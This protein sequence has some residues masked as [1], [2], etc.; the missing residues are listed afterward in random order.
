MARMYSPGYTY[1][2]NRRQRESRTR[3]GQGLVVQSD[4]WKR[5][6]KNKK[7]A[8]QNLA[9]EVAVRSNYYGFTPYYTGFLQRSWSVPIQFNEVIIEYNTKYAEYVWEENKSGVPYWAIKTFEQDKYELLREY[10]GDLFR[11]YLRK[12]A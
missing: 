11:K 7:V 2:K 6:G 3:V 12:K 1:I 5:I 4:I 10:A 9:Y 8:T